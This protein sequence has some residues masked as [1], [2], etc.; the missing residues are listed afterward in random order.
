MTSPYLELVLN[1]ELCSDTE[2]ELGPAEQ[3]DEAKADDN[4][5]EV[6]CD[7]VLDSVNVAFRDEN[8]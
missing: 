5:S 2:D 4:L 1:D 3:E 8:L 7:V 6:Q